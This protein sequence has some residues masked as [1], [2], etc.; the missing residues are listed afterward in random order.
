M[1]FISKPL[2]FSQSLELWF[3]IVLGLQQRIIS[4]HTCR[5]WWDTN[6]HAWH[7]CDPDTAYKMDTIECV[8]KQHVNST[9]IGCDCKEEEKEKRK[10]K[11]Y[12]V[13]KF[14][15]FEEEL[16]GTCYGVFG[17]ILLQKQIQRFEVAALQCLVNQLL[18][19][20]TGVALKSPNHTHLG[21]MTF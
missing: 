15:N 7:P 21:N 20:A 12:H 6:L 2:S 4:C 19:L 13:Y 5:G 9:I 17:W 16:L 18:Q 14:V 11:V 8:S 3:L 1:H 10:E